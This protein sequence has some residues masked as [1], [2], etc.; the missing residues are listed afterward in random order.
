APASGTALYA[1]RSPKETKAP[2][3]AIPVVNGVTFVT[4]HLYQ[5]A[6]TGTPTS[7]ADA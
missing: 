3:N 1:T 2:S 7:L 6:D 4:A 5:T